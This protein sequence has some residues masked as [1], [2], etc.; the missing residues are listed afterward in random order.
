MKYIQ[1]FEQRT[2]KHFDNEKLRKINIFQYHYY[3]PYYILEV[4]ESYVCL[5]K[6][7]I[8]L[9]CKMYHISPHLIN[10]D[11]FYRYYCYH[12]YFISYSLT[13]PH[14]IFLN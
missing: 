10:H 1:I 7:I 4:Y 13:Y 12:Y 11:Y 6:C 8:C 9:S 14:L 5:V 3:F 2:Y